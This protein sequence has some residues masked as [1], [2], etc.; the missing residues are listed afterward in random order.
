MGASAALTALWTVGAC[1]PALSSIVE[2]KDKPLWN[3]DPAGPQWGM[4]EPV[5]GMDEFPGGE[6]YVHL[7]GAWLL[8][9]PSPHERSARSCDTCE[10]LEKGLSTLTISHSRSAATHVCSGLQPRG[11][12]NGWVH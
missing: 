5:F 1:C 10:L 8:S 11:N 9:D 4:E 3:V 7:D 12:R 2:L 6:A